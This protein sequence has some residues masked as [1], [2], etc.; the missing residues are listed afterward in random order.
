MLH[1]THLIFIRKIEKSASI[2][3]RTS[4][5]KF[6]KLGK[7][8]QN[9]QHIL[10]SIASLLDVLGDSSPFFI[11]CLKPNQTKLP[12][13]YDFRVVPRAVDKA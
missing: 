9:D 6:S 1:R 3:P 12:L 4:H 7:A 11:R 5:R 8:S 10:V 13:D 2:Q